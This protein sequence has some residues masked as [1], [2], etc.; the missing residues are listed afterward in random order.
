M[1]AC[2]SKGSS[3]GSKLN[4]SEIYELRIEKRSFEEP[5]SLQFSILS[6]SSD[7]SSSLL[8]FGKQFQLF[9]LSQNTASSHVTVNNT[10]T[11]RCITKLAS[12]RVNISFSF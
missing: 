2:L 6:N 12:A 9:R 10:V 11:I 5:K 1:E 7:T 3:R 4:N 8:Y